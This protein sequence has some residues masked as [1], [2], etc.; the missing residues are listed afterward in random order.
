MIVQNLVYIAIVLSYLLVGVTV[1]RWLWLRLQ[2]FARWLALIFLT[3]QIVAIVL[4]EATASASG[5]VHWLWHLDI[6][7]N[8]PS[9]LASMQLALVGAAAILVAWLWTKPPAWQRLYFV[10]IAIVFL[11][12]AYDEFA[13]VHEGNPYWRSNYR[14]IG[15]GIALS[16]ALLAL[17]NP[18]PSRVWFFCLPLGLAIGGFGATVLDISTPQCGGQG[19]AYILG[20]CAQILVLEESLEL[21]GIWLALVAILGHLSGISPAPKAYLRIL[22]FA[23]P[24]LWMI[25]LS[26]RN[27][28]SPVSTQVNASAFENDIWLHRHKVDTT[29]RPDRVRARLHLSGG[30]WQFSGLG[31]S[32]SLLDGERMTVISD[33]DRFAHEQLEFKLA[34]GYVP[35]YL[36]VID[37]EIPPETP[38][39]RLILIVLTIWRQE[40]GEFIRQKILATDQPQLSDTQMVLDE[41]VIQSASGPPS[42]TTLAAFDNGFALEAVELPACAVPGGIVDVNFAWRADS[43]G[44][45]DFAQFLHFIH[46]ESGA[47]WNHDQMPLGSRLPTRL[48]YSGLADSEIWRISL[49]ADL[50]TGDYSLFTGLYRHSDLVRA[51][52]HSPDGGVFPDARIPIGSM[53]VQMAC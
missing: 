19:A 36:Q 44:S 29:T 2:P 40:N 18:W 38:T 7:W 49:P 34:P 53:P 15:F 12:F 48:W 33:R 25:F 5:L 52:A 47:M 8:I 41:M 16:S 1:Y 50:P 9:A 3:A 45:E 11:Y 28:I 30:G 27:V 26:Q 42:A 23:A 24:A 22:L 31:Y 35:A 4:S 6:E 20:E 43:A 39:N 10:G 13:T 37:V 21:L 17:R 46:A 32:I 14:L 51:R